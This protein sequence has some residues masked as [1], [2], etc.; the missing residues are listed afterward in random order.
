MAATFTYAAVYQVEAVCRTP[1]RTGGTD[2]DP[3]QILRDRDGRAFLQGSSLAGALR[4]WLEVREDSCTV[5][6]LFGS[7]KAPG[8]LMVSDA[9]FDTASEQYLRPRL[10]IDG[11][12]ASAATG[13]KFDMA[14]IGRGAVLR[15]SLTWLGQPACTGKELSAIEELLAAMHSGAIRLGA[16]KSNGFGRLSLSVKKRVFDLMDKDDRAAWLADELEGQPLTLPQSVHRHEVLFT[17]KGYTD[18]ILVKTAPQSYKAGDNYRS[19]TPNLAEGE[20]AVLP[21][22]SVK[23][24]VRSRAEMIARFRGWDG[25]R[26]DT[27]FGRSSGDEDNG[28][29]GKV[30]FEDALLTGTKKK[31][32]RIH[33]DRFTGGVFRGGLFTEEPSC[34]ALELRVSAPDEPAS[35]ALLLYALRDLGLGLYTFGSGWAVGRGVV[36]VQ[37]IRAAAPDGRTAAL[38]WNDGVAMDDPDGLFRDWLEKWGEACHEN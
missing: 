28:R 30:R 29:A 1:L 3:E 24:A 8:R 20:Q 14:H 18:S 11:E 9:V 33:I 22:S 25:E 32:S 31:I 7:Q 21:G 23:G 4:G 13:G 10:R 6:A 38:R 26:I 15:F 35:C 2:G 5:V 36:A 19:Y 16:Q 37:E 27:L 17:V 34:T 12:T